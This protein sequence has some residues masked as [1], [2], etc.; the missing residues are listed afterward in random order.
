MA[1]KYY[2]QSQKG[3]GLLP[4]IGLFALA[5]IAM[6]LLAIRAMAKRVSS[7]N[8][9]AIAQAAIERAMYRAGYS[10]QM[11]KWWTA[12]S[13]FETTYWTSPIFRRANNLWGMT[14]ASRNTTAIGILE[15]APEK[16]AVYPSLD[17]SAEDIVLFMRK[18]WRYPDNFVTLAD[19]I[20]YMK[21]RNYF[22]SSE[23][24]YYEGVKS[25]YLKLYGEKTF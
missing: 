24:K 9:S 16:Q 7:N 14:L 10:S 18:R 20:R 8:V 19:L 21:Q 3:F 1:R 22:T 23:V 6:L 11:I 5:L 15:D 2:L 4:K 17:A 12:I 13:A 25:T